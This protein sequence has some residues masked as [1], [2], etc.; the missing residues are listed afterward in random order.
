MS[1]SFQSRKQILTLRGVYFPEILNFLKILKIMSYNFKSRKQILTLR[2]VYD[3]KVDITPAQKCHKVNLT[4]ML[5]VTTLLI[6]VVNKL[7][8][9]SSVTFQD[10]ILTVGCFF[11][12]PTSS[13]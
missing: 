6:S 8:Q 5:T 10:L 11:R 2:G 7:S 4:V 9:V 3:I 13:G 12:P 1:Y